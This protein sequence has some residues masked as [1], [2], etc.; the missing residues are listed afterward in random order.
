MS[1]RGFTR[2]DFI[3]KV[4]SWNPYVQYPPFLGANGQFGGSFEIPKQK[5]CR[6]TV[7][8]SVR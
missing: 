6:E 2:V 8:D 5:V 4:V 7:R 1:Q 3:Q